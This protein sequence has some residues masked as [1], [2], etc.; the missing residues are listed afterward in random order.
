M[1]CE[2]PTDLIEYC[3]DF[4]TWEN[5][6]NW[7]LVRKNVNWKMKY[8]K[9]RGNQLLPKKMKIRQYCVHNNC[10]HHCLTYLSWTRGYERSFIPWCM[11]HTPPLILNDIE[12]FCMG[13]INEYGSFI[14][15]ENIV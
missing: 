4:M 15:D 12:M 7:R 9:S 10:C 6:K 5:F 13:G 1:L 11:I 14:S 2:L 3:E 8:I